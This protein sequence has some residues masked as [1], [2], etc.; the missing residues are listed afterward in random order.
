ML[1]ERQL[2]AHTG[3]PLLGS[4]TLLR[5][6]RALKFVMLFMK[7]VSADTS[8]ERTVADIA[9]EAY[10]KSLANYHPWL[11]RHTAKV[12]VYALPSRDVLFSKLYPGS[13]DR[14]TAHAHKRL[15]NVSETI[16]K[17]Y[18]D[19]DVLFTKYEMHDLP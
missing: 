4:R 19:V 10:E 3:G 11:L 6:H 2:H 17:L 13:Y 1:Y 12:A 16:E 18:S 9:Y 15:N 8:A 5:L 7:H 14:R